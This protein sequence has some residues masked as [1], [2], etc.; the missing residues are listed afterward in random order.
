MIVGLKDINTNLINLVFC[1]FCY[2][3][4]SYKKFKLRYILFFL[5]VFKN[6]ILSETK[7]SLP[8]KFSVKNN[9]VFYS[10]TNSGSP[11]YSGFFENQNS[12]GTDVT[13]ITQSGVYEIL[14]SK[15]NKSYYG[16]TDS[17]VNRFNTHLR[18]L[19]K[20]THENSNLKARLYANSSLEGFRFIV[21]HSGPEWGDVKKRT[22]CQDEYIAANADRC[23]NAIE[24][25]TTDR[26]RKLVMAKGKL[27]SSDRKA[28]EGENVCRNT[29]RGYCDDPN[30]LDYYYVIQESEAPPGSVPIF[31]QKGDSPSLLFISYQQCINAGFTSNTQNAR[32]KIQRKEPGWRYA[33]V[34]E[35]GRPLR[36]PYVLKPG[37]I[38]YSEW[39]KQQK[40]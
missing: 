2:C 39:V 34:D 11:T 28:A 14:D 23:Y 4:F 32:R 24:P 25:S 18:L 30:N 13:C 9:I 29:I 21:L 36:Q 8:N 31:G 40:N 10:T 37:E 1:I 27:Y 33:H 5:N 16:E 3:L 15:Y 20:G 26:K 19:K 35:S 22:Q 7:L 6:Y 38:S 12:S 17:L